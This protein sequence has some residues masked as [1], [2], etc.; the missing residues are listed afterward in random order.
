MKGRSALNG[1]L[2]EIIR[3]EAGAGVVVM[4][5]HREVSPPYL[6]KT[7]QSNFKAENLLI[8]LWD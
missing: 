6:W 7:V 8:G 1:F 4:R 5:C 2:L 3:V